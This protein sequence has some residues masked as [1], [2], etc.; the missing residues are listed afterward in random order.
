MP[1]EVDEPDVQRPE[2][3]RPLEVEPLALED[4]E[5]LLLVGGDD[6]AGLAVGV[7]PERLP[8]RMQEVARPLHEG[9]GPHARV[10]LVYGDHPAEVDAR[11][12]HYAD[13]ARQLHVVL[14]A[15]VAGERRLAPTVLQAARKLPPPHPP[16]PGD[17]EA[18]LIPLDEVWR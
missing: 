11:P 9:E 17:A 15:S 5:V 2:L 7:V 1:A 3:L 18:G 6:D 14:H 10:M 16:G 12:D 13:L 8:G 4:H